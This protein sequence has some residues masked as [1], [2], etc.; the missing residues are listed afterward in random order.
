MFAGLWNG[1]ISVFLGQLFTG[2]RNGSFDWALGIFLVPFAAVGIAS[3]IAAIYF[4]LSFFAPRVCV[5][6][7]Q[8]VRLGETSDLSWTF[9]GRVQRIE[10]LRILLEGTEEASYRRGTSTS[11]DRSVFAEVE[12]AQASDLTSIRSGQV[13][14]TVPG[15][16]LPTFRSPNNA[17]V[18]TLKVQGVIARFP[19]VDDSFPLTV[20]APVQRS[21]SS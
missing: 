4:F 10:R 19:D 2:A 7:A 13:R 8:P 3:L 11:T 1:I 17:I 21:R 14:L 12:L 9:S 20:L 18:W 6:V 15:D 16:S 5:S